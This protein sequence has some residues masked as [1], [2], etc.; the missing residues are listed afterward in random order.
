MTFYRMCADNL[1][2]GIILFQ[3]FSDTHYSTGCSDGGNKIVDSPVCLFPYLL[4]CRFIMRYIIILIRELVRHKIPVGEPANQFSGFKNCSVCSQFAVGK[5]YLCTE[6]PYHFYP[7][8][9]YRAAHHYFNLISLYSSYHSK[10]Y[11][12]IPGSRLNNN[13]P[14]LK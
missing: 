1:D 9:R 7:F 4:S 13:F 10:A 3:R 12:G 6:G 11:S 2:L 5:G 14:V 8:N